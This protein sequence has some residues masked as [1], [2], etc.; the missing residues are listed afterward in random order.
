MARESSKII[1]QGKQEREAG[2]ARA[3]THT[4]PEPFPHR[5][6]RPWRSQATHFRHAALGQRRQGENSCADPLGMHLR[7]E[8][9]WPLQSGSQGAEG[10]A[11]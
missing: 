1:L 11:W 2:S 10:G 3:K 4:E 8:Q 7:S 5:V 9:H 6:R